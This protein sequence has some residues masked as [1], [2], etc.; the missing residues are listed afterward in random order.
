MDQKIRG[1]AGRF[2]VFAGGAILVGGT[3][4]GP[5]AGAAEVCP[6]KVASTVLHPLPAPLIVTLTLKD[7]SGA[8]R[9]VSRD[10]GDGLRS[11]GQRVGAPANARLSLSYRTLS[12]ADN[13]YRRHQQDFN[14]PG[15]P[16][17]GWSDWS[18]SNAPWLRG[19]ETA[20][21]PDFPRYD[22]FHPRPPGQPGTV[23]L[24]AELRNARTGVLDWVGMVQCVPRES[25]R[26]SL[27]WQLGALTGRAMQA[28]PVRTEADPGQPI[29]TPR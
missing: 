6:G 28:G 26:H 14:Q 23:V 7:A 12:E 9:G 22:M 4:F 11:A 2:L 3:A 21:L 16:D 1:A 5:R 25:G 27:A 19:G 13:S 29:V 20:A 18:G 15:G 8:G 10:F 24:R 17:S